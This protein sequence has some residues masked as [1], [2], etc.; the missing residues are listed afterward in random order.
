LTRRGLTITIALISILVLAGLAHATNTF[1]LKDSQTNTA[2]DEAEFES[3]CGTDPQS[4]YAW[5]FILNGLD[6]GTPAG[7]LWAWFETDGWLGPVTS[8]KVVANGKTQHFFVY[9]STN[10]TLKNAYS[11]ADSDDFNNL[12]LSHVCSPGGE[13][14][15]FPTA[16][17]PLVLA[18]GGYLALMRFRRK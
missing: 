4:P 3:D 5:H 9:T 2:F 10:D 18:L 1:W 14:P 7:E 8:Q 15:E 6:S 16:A 17:A 11:E 12:V 13:I